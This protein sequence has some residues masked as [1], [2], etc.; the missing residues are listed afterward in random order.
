M[1]KSYDD[2]Q[3]SLTEICDSRD[4]ARMLRDQLS[5]EYR[6]LQEQQPSL[7]AVLRDDPRRRQGLEAMRKAIAAADRAIQSIDQALREMGGAPDDP[8]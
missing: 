3:H 4:Q 7:P 5:A 6:R 1:T 2:Y 8:Q